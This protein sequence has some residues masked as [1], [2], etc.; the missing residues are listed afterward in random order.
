VILCAR[1]SEK[2]HFSEMWQDLDGL[3]SVGVNSGAHQIDQFGTTGKGSF[4]DKFR[5]WSEK[6]NICMHVVHRVFLRD[7]E[8]T[9]SRSPCP[10]Y[11]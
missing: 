2:C 9:R 4:I 10:P 5:V 7:K 6:A 11:T 1:E 3:G 8:R